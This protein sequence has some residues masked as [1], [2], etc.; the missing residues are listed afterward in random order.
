MKH[1][2]VKFIAECLY[3][4]QVKYEHHRPGGT[5]HRISF[6]NRSEKMIAMDFVVGLLKT[7]SKFE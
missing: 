4:Q 1:D 6:L 3:C 5:L 7:L 2:N